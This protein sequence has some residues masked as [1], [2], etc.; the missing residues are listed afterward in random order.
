MITSH[1]HVLSKDDSGIENHQHLH[2]IE[3]V[4][5]QGVVHGTILGA[6][7]GTLVAVLV[8]A[9]GYLTTLP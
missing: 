8:L 5:K 3:S 7:L 2:N 9:I 6:I 1:I 4:F